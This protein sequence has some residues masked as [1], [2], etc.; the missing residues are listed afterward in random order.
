MSSDRLVVVALATAQSGKEQ[1]LADRLA[2][3]ARESWKEP[4]VVSYAVHDVVGSPG[5]FMMVEVYENQA[6]FDAHLN[7][8]HVKAIIADVP[9]LVDGELVVHQGTASP[10]SEGEKGS[11]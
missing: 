1:E 7:T 9:S 4:G 11:L 8:E 10:F 6:A 5:Q 3:V 2:H